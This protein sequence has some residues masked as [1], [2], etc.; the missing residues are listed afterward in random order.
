MSNTIK[1]SNKIIL[2]PNYRIK[3]D[4]DRQILY[5]KRCTDFSY[6]NHW[7]SVIHPY[8][9][10]ILSMFTQNLEYRE[11]VSSLSSHFN[12]TEKEIEGLLE[13]FIE[14]K[15]PFFTNFEGEDIEFP[16]NVLVRPDK[17]THYDYSIESFDGDWTNVDLKYDRLHRGPNSLTYV[18]TTKC[19]TDCKYCYCDKTTPYTPISH[20][21]LVKIIDEAKNL[22][23]ANIDI[24]GGEVFCFPD[25][26]WLVKTLVEMDMSPTYISTKV[27]LTSKIIDKLKAT[28]YN[29][30][31][32]LSLDSLTPAV[33]ESL[34]SVDKE[35]IERIKQGIKI[36]ASTDFKVQ[37]ATIL[38]KLN[39]NKDEIIRLYEFIKDIPNLQYWEIRVP[40]TSVYPHKEWKN[41]QCDKEE[42][43]QI[44]DFIKSDINPKA[45]IRIRIS[46]SALYIPHR[47]YKPCDNELAGGRCSMLKSHLF[48]L[49]DGKVTICEEAYWTP[50]FILGDLNTQ[51]IHE[52]WHSERIKF[53]INRNEI[54]SNSTCYGCKVKDECRDNGRRCIIKVLRAYG[55]HRW[56]EA[57]P[58]CIYA[59]KF[60]EKTVI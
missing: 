53:I 38:T 17:A 1:F 34:Y 26:E 22:K 6:S 46:D 52:I 13:P 24:V 11:I 32:Q 2:N 3:N 18:L 31:L 25:W 33:L 28:K 36:L 41:L 16:I 29:F 51:S 47:K 27:P 35:Y 55:P 10:C 37:A 43:K 49:P 8:Y 57:D 50:A 20:D 14:N 44:I 12:I 56:D 4:V 40:N 19:V 5:S 42:L 30:P 21:T 59:P 15:E 45:K 60:S 9:S 7:I 48:I 58:R 54:R 23:I 39:S